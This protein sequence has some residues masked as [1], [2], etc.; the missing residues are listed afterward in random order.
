MGWEQETLK[1]FLTKGAE[2]A[3]SPSLSLALVFPQEKGHA[4]G[5]QAMDQMQEYGCVHIKSRCLAL[6]LQGTEKE[7]PFASSPTSSQRWHEGAHG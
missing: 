5:R 6:A 4:L 2:T 1:D 3:G 7:A